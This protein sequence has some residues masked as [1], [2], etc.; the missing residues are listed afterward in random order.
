[1]QLPAHIAFGQ[2]LAQNPKVNIDFNLSDSCAQSLSVNALCELANNTVENV[3]GM[4]ELSYAPLWGGNTLRQLIADFHQKANNHEAQLAIEDVLTFCGAQ[5]ALS[6]I[7]QSVFSTNTSFTRNDLA[8][9]EIVVIT[10]CYPSLVTMAE[11]LGIKVNCLLLDPQQAW[12]VTFEELSSLVNDK[13]RLIVVNSP[14]NPSGAIIISELADEIL[15]LAKQFDCYLLAD[16]VSQMSNHHHLPLAH[17]YLDFDK[18]IVVS[19]L[20]KSFGLSGVR[21]GWSVTKNK[22]LL[23]QLLAIK[24]QSSICTSV[25]DEK[26]A[27]LALIHHEKIIDNNNN[28]TL[29]NIL[30]F[31]QFVD[32]NPLSFSWHPPKAGLLGLVKCHSQIPLL[33]WAEQLAEQAGIF[34]YPA[35]LFGLNEQYFRIGLGKT[36]FS[37][38]LERL[39]HFIDSNLVTHSD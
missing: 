15:A 6:A 7:Y 29:Q 26:L 23:K 28:I 37:R 2:R 35:S 13:T 14:H 3:L 24:A 8:E 27:E 39:Q 22:Q 19:V 4:Q 16:D 31:Q 20:S 17:K 9:S 11:Q 12:Q 25:V 18:A 36:N 34:V 38:I 1:M 33:E 30:L 21:I 10:P 32:D 5:E